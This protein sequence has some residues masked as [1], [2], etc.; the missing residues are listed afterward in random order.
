V[1]CSISF[2]ISHGGI[3]VFLS[4][5]SDIPQLLEILKVHQDFGNENRFRVLPL[6]GGIAPASQTLSI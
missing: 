2:I 5:W 6:H 3:L 1:A 4:G